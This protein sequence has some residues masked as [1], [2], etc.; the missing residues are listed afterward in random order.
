VPG[1]GTMATT[2]KSVPTRNLGL[3]DRVRSTFNSGRYPELDRLPISSL[4]CHE[5]TSASAVGR[6]PT[7]EEL[8][9]LHTYWRQ[10]VVQCAMPFTANHGPQRS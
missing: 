1:S 6:F 9:R 7:S 8:R 5:E 2:F 10:G 4:T 3:P